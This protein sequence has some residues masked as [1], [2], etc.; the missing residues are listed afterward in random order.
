MPIYEY[1]CDLCRCMWEE[2][3]K[4]SDPVLT[5]CKGCGK[6]GG[7]RKLFSGKIAFHLKGGGWYKYGYSSEDQTLT[8]AQRK[9]NE[10]KTNPK[11]EKQLYEDAFEG[12]VPKEEDGTKITDSY[13][14]DEFTAEQLHNYHKEGIE[15]SLNAPEHEPLSRIQEEIGIR[16]QE[17]HKN[18]QW[19]KLAGISREYDA[20]R[21]ELNTQTT[22]ENNN[23]V[24][25]R[26]ETAAKDKEKKVENIA[27][28]DTVAKPT[29]I[30]K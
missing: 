22:L 27:R 12:N 15:K 13:H 9:V 3:Q 29:I 17:A 19:D 5:E 6:E 4:F 20:Q 21:A 24:D 30:K 11:K 10:L 1:G 8:D 2:V 26:L 16:E 7:V 25:W 23:S 28:K 18:K 14:G